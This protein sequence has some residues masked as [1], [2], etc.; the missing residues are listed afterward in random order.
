M[1]KTRRKAL[2]EAM[3]LITKFASDFAT[4]TEIID[5]AANEERE[6][7]DNLGDKAKEGDKGQALDEAASTL[8]AL[9]SAFNELDLD[10]AVSKIDDARG[11]E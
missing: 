6:A 9:Q 2:G 5:R 7:Y 11:V 1:N 10:D 4:V 8:E 3:D